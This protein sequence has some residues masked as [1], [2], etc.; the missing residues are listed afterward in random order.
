MHI[1]VNDEGMGEREG[2]MTQTTKLEGRLELTGQEHGDLP[3]VSAS[4]ASALA[5]SKVMPHSKPPSGCDG[6]S[7]TQTPPIRIQRKRTKGWKMP[8]NTI[9]V[10]RGSKWGN[11]FVVGRSFPI[12]TDPLEPVG[13]RKTP[14]IA[15]AKLAVMLF[16]IFLPSELRIAARHELRGKNLACWCPP[17]T[18]S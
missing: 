3:E 11:P 9:Y 7:N 10:G 14:Y 17:P 15:D 13:G 12:P 6:P 2:T 5:S 18:L 1:F 16:R 4:K 8:P